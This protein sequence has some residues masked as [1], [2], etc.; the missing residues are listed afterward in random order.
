MGREIRRVPPNWEHP[1]YTRHNV[2]PGRSDRDL[3]TYI[4]MFDESFPDAIE[5]WVEGYR[6]WQAGTH[7]SLLDKD[8]T[9]EGQEYWEYEGPP[10]RI[11]FY[12]PAFTEKPTWYQ[13]Y[14]TVSEG[15]PVT[16]PFATPEELVDYLVSHGDNWAHGGRLSRVAATAFVKRGHAF[17]MVAVEGQGVLGPYEQHKL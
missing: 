3:G 7:E 9:T 17:S 8:R 13:V 5:S 11:E 4:P 2:L 14:E 12:R 6:Q 10:P 15:T 16:P 1:R